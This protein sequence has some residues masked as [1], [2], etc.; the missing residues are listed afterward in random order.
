M[1]KYIYDYPEQREIAKDLCM[2][3]RLFI[4]KQTGYA[5]IYIDSWCL[6]KRRN[7]LISC[8]AKILQR[9]NIEKFETADKEYL[10]C[11]D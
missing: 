7:N 2:A 9:L 6:G 8:M 5:K 3:D 10:L 4:A 1:K 11:N